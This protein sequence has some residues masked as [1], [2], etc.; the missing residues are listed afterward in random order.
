MDLK[1]FFPTFRAARIRSFFRTLGYPEPVANLLAG[2]CTTSTPRDLWKQASG[3]NDRVQIRESKDLYFRTHLPQG[4]PTSPALAN[5]CC[6]RLDCRLTGL[7]KSVGA[8]Y[9]RY[10]DDLAFSGD[11]DFEGRVERF[12]TQV[13][14]ILK[15]GGF[16]VHHRKTRIMRQGVRQ[17]L[18][19]LVVNRRCN[20]QRRDFDRLKAILSN[21][22]RYGPETQNRES[23]PDFRSHLEG[24]VS[25]VEMINPQKGERLRRLFQEIRWE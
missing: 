1:D 17:H 14:A 3:L 12:S 19:G 21:C 18:A 5:L 2:I 11:D 22:L 7:A 25:F 6:Y 10:A 24:K 16:A 8:R 13:A 9:T 20:V 15:E 4:A 23:H